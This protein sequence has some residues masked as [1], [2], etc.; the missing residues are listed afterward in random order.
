VSESGP[1]T[2]GCGCGAVRYEVTK[3]FLSASYC[4]CTRCRRRTGRGASAN[5]RAQP[6]SFRVVEG[7]EHLRAWAPDGGVEKLFCGLCG[8]G[9]FSRDP[10]DHDVVGVRL[11]SVDGDPGIRPQWHQFTAYAPVW[12]PVP[13]DGLPRY[14]ESR[15]R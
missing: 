12:E 8:S 6:G 3:P 9:L 5:A 4:H 2:G 11:G 14:P 15:T 13:D 1:I 10:Q 7:E